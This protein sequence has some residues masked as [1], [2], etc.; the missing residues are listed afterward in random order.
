MKSQNHRVGKALQ[1]PTPSTMQEIHNY[2]LHTPHVTPTPCQKMAFHVQ[3][4]ES[5]SVSDD[6]LASV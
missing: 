2:L 1:G 4:T 5:A 6:C 3:F